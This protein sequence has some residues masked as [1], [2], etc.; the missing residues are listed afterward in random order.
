MDDSADYVA[1][2]RRAGLRA[3][4]FTGYDGVTAFLAAEGVATGAS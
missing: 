1:G 4:L 2:A 3:H